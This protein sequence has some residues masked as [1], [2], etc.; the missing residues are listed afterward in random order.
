MKVTHENNI[1][2]IFDSQCIWWN[3]VIP[4]LERGRQ[5]T[6]SCCPKWVGG[7]RNPQVASSYVLF[8]V[9]SRWSMHRKIDALR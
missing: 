7:Q 5:E 2:T 9:G 6:D 1:P 8:S 4:K 3:N